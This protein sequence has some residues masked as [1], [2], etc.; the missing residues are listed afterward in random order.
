[1]QELSHLIRLFVPWLVSG[2]RNYGES[3]T[4]NCRG[5]FFDTVE[6]SRIRGSVNQ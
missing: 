2:A 1:M 5:E 4:G 6:R 3:R